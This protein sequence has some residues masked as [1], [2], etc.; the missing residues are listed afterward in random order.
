MGAADPNATIVFGA[1]IDPELEDEI[2]ITVVATG[3]GDQK[4]DTED[5]RKKE[6]PDDIVSFKTQKMDV[7]EL[8]IPAILRRRK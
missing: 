8:E 2:K 5:F 7:E 3:L 4:V 1:V 6:A